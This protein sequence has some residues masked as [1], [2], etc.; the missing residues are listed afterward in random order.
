VT[1]LI[2]NLRLDVG[3]LHLITV[4]SWDGADNGNCFPQ[5]CFLSKNVFPKVSLQNLWFK[6]FPFVQKYMC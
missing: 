2:G 5:I 3:N 4:I 1:I 6:T